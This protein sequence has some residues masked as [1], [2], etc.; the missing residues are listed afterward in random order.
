LPLLSPLFHYI[1][2]IHGEYAHVA[3]TRRSAASRRRATT[4]MAS[5]ALPA[6]TRMRVALPRDIF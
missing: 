4:L 2:I 1:L 6:D 5:G 3:R